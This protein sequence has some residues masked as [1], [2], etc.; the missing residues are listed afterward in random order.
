MQKIKEICIPSAKFKEYALPMQKIRKIC[1]AN[2]RIKKSLYCQF[3]TKQ[4]LNF[5]LCYPGIT[6]LSSF[7]SKL[8]SLYMDLDS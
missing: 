5:V 7:L 6:Q 4:A 8:L 1:T 3:D 2:A